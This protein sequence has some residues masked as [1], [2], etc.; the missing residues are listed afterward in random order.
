[1]VS[2]GLGSSQGPASR[3]HFPLLVYWK[4]PGDSPLRLKSPHVKGSQDVGLER[5][6]AE[7]S[8]DKIFRFGP[9]PALLKID[10]P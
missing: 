6:E 10:P 2:T 7:P 9:G 3:I 8:K 5:M 4:A 1:M